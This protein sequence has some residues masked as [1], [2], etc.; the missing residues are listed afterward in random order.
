M[1]RRIVCIVLFASFFFI[2]CLSIVW[3]STAQIGISQTS[4]EVKVGDEFTYSSQLS[5]VSGVPSEIAN[6]FYLRYDS[7][8]WFKITISNITDSSIV[9]YSMVFHFNDGTESTS[10]PFRGSSYLDGRGG[11]FLVYPSS[12]N[13]GDSLYPSPADNDARSYIITETVPVAYTDGSRMTN[14]VTVADFGNHL[15]KGDLYFDKETGMLVEYICS[16]PQS[17]DSAVAALSWT[18]KLIGSTAW[19][20]GSS[21]S[22]IPSATLA[23]TLQPSSTTNTTPTH[24]SISNNPTSS[25]SIATDNWLSSIALIVIAFL[26]AVIVFLLFYIRKRRTIDSKA[27]S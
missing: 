2:L 4:I 25:Q 27:H 21:P 15:P 3:T 11:D 22:I 6:T 26:L 7:L 17:P 1:K 20:G 23:P 12:L 13:A 19:S 5:I 8:E 16:I 18:I 9:D 24:S 10:G 14:H